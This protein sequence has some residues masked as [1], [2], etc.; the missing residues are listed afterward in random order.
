MSAYHPDD[1]TL[2]NYAAGS[3]S[4]PQALAVSVHLCFCHECRDLVWG[5]ASC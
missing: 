2:M 3:L 1:M 4:I 5:R